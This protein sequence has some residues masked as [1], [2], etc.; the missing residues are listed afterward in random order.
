MVHQCLAMLL[1]IDDQILSVE[2]KIE[3]IVP[4][5]AFLFDGVDKLVCCAEALPE[6]LDALLNRFPSMFPLLHWV[7]IHLIWFL[8]ILLSTLIQLGSKNAREKEIT[9]DDGK[10]NAVEHTKTVQFERPYSYA[11]AARNHTEIPKSVHFEDNGIPQT[12]KAVPT[13]VIHL[14]VKRLHSW[15]TRIKALEEPLSAGDSPMYSSYQ[16]ANSSPV[17]D[18]SQE[19]NHPFSQLG[20]TYK[21]I[22]ERD[23]KEDEE[24]EGEEGERVEEG[25]VHHNKEEE[26]EESRCYVATQLTT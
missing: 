21:E 26:E 23:K 15:K 10:A 25:H 3:R 4:R 13:E 22:L 19:E 12:T 2:S 7:V 16:S 18:C 9:V 24:R 17:S 5:S 11:D 14:S 20:C 8:N 1:I 6:Q